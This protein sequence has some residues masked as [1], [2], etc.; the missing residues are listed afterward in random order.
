M[1]ILAFALAAGCGGDGDGDAT[2][3]GSQEA[4]TYELLVQRLT[5]AGVQATAETTS[6]DQLWT[7]V[8]GRHLNIEGEMVQVFSHEST[9]IARQ[10]ADRISP[11]GASIGRHQVEWLEPPRF[12]RDGPLIVLYVG[13]NETVAGAL[14]EALGPPFAGTGA[15]P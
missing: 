1:G 2:S 10:E 14:A 8:P 15:V 13:T 5:Q 6:V 4:M 3:Q 12:Y 11:D 7:S 9:A